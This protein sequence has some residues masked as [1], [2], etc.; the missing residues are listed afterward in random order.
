MGRM[1]TLNK[2]WSFFLQK[3]TDRDFKY[4]LELIRRENMFTDIEWR[5]QPDTAVVALS[6]NPGRLRHV[7]AKYRLAQSF[8]NSFPCRDELKLYKFEAVGWLSTLTL[9]LNCRPV[10]CVLLSEEKLFSKQQMS[11]CRNVTSL[12]SFPN[13]K[14]SGILGSFR[15]KLART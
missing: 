1:L 7:K 8:S 10:V 12:T 6:E 15:Y 14:S 2:D 9:I 11:C 13:R 5:F 4:T 3:N